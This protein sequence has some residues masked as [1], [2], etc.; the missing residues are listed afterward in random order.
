MACCS[1][2]PDE[3]QT[4][5]ITSPAG[6]ACILSVQMECSY[7]CSGVH[8]IEAKLSWSF[9]LYKKRCSYLYS[10]VRH[11]E[12]KMQGGSFADKPYVKH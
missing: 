8:R 3:C 11:I 7:L 9:H 4:I 12:G 10:G 6:R 2:L 1:S 5:L